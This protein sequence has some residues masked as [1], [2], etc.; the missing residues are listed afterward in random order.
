[1]RRWIKRKLRAWLIAPEVKRLEEAFFAMEKD[2]R[3]LSGAVA[4]ASGIGVDARFP[5]GIAEPTTVVLVSRLGKGRVQI[6]DLPGVENVVELDGLVRE[7]VSRYGIRSRP[8][9][10]LPGGMRGARDHLG[11]EEA[12]RLART[13][14]RRR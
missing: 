8:V 7:L 13:R 9:W 5:R 1:M 10:D 4:G 6:V 12:A 14:G 2:L 11:L 3:K